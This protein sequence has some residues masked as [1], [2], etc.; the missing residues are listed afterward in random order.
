MHPKNSPVRQTVSKAEQKIYADVYDV[1]T[2]GMVVSSVLYAIGVIL[3][4]MHPRT[5]PLTR[6]FVL[7]NYQLGNVLHGFAHFRPGAF[8]FVATVILILTPVSRVVISIYAFYS[9]RDWKY[10]LV[11][12]IVFLVIV[13]T[14]VLGRLGL[15]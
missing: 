13:L 14:V 6:A 5:I 2:A 9:E 10:V 1:L 11:T 7:H 3:A 4:L 15:Q 8:M 12:G